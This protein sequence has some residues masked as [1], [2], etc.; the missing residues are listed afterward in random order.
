MLSKLIVL[1]RET[2]PK[3]AYASKLR[4]QVC[5]NSQVNLIKESIS[6]KMLCINCVIQKSRRLNTKKISE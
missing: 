3:V 4:C 6:G 2:G 1:N 5:D